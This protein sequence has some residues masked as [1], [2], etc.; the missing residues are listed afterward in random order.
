[1]NNEDGHWSEDRTH[2][3]YDWEKI[4]RETGWSIEEINMR[5]VSWCR[6][7]PKKI[8]PSIKCAICGWGGCER[9]H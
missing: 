5:G 8:A 9:I 7:N 6:R 4:S 3:I 1:M 2:F